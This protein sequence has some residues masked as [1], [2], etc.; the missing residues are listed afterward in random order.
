MLRRRI[1]A[2]LGSLLLSTLIAAAPAI[3]ATITVTTLVD[4]LNADGDCSL[5]EAVRAA[6]T[7]LAVDDCDAG[8]GDQTDTIT[9]PAG[10]GRDGAIYVVSRRR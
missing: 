1:S 9:V 5:R 3:A 4:E 10:R 8:Q 7:N 6:N 2:T